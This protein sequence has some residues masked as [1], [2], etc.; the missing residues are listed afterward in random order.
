VL[1]LSYL[2]IF[3]DSRYFVYTN[4]KIIPQNGYLHS[5][6]SVNRNLAQGAS[7]STII[8][9][10]RGGAGRGRGVIFTRI[11]RDDSEGVAKAAAATAAAGRSAVVPARGRVI[12]VWDS[13]CE[14]N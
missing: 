4:R 1:R 7:G 14:Y 5:F 8:G 13:N 12:L 3:V 2:E 11:G 6:G 9:A 10:G